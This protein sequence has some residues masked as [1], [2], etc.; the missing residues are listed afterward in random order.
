MCL[1]RL[2][3]SSRLESVAG[4]GGVCV[5]RA[6]DS[7]R[8]EPPRRTSQLDVVTYQPRRARCTLGEGAR[9][10]LGGGLSERGRPRAAAGAPTGWR[11]RCAWGNA[12][13][14]AV[15]GFMHAPSC[16]DR[17]VC[18][19]HVCEGCRGR[20]HACPV[21]LRARTTRVC[22]RDERC[23]SGERHA[24]HERGTPHARAREEQSTTRMSKTVPS[25]LIDSPFNP[26]VSLSCC[27]THP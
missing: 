23:H 10:A 22:H 15:G 24:S 25:T 21:V 17:V 2:P 1:C 19:G 26:S 16:A 9:G 8:Q 13:G 6:C 14:A 20:F 7:L 12:C 5:W 27:S 4:D 18:A 3:S 11:R